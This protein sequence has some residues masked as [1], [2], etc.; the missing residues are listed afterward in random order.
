MEKSVNN[1]E[2]GNSS[3]KKARDASGQL[4]GQLFK[5]SIFLLLSSLVADELARLLLFLWF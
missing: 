5:L 4:M 1:H 2:A 3:R